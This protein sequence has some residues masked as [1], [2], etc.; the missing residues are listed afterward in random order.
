EGPA[1]GGELRPADGPVARNGD[2]LPDQPVGGAHER[3]VLGAEAGVPQREHGEPG[4]PA[5]RLARLGP[6]AVALV[7][8]EALPALD[9]TAERLVLEAVP[10]RDEHQDRPDPRRLDPAPGAV[11]LLV[12]THPPLGLLDRDPLQPREGGRGLALPGA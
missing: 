7:D 12:L 9:R 3:R 2:L 8:R 11:G 4:V 1:A 5:R 6:K 10:E